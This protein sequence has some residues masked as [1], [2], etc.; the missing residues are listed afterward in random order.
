MAYDERLERDRTMGADVYDS[1]LIELYDD[2][3]SSPSHDRS[4]NMCDNSGRC[5][6]DS[7]A[8]GST[9][10]IYCGKELIQRN[11]QW[12]TWDADLA[13]LTPQPQWVLTRPT[14]E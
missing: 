13:A 4:R 6:A 10:C 5:T 14:E 11:G 8:K 3:G 12:F 1:R 7:E 2:E 9:N